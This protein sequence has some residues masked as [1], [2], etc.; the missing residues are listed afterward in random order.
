MSGSEAAEPP[1]Q[2]W[3]YLQ[4]NLQ[5]T[6]N[7]PKIEALLRRAAKAVCHELDLEIIPAVMSFGYSDG[8]LAHD[9]NLAEGLPAKNGP[10]V[11][12]GM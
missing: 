10:F 2:R 8:I 5:V 12:R 1:A 6:E 9:P 7:M 11:V 4:Q 3:L